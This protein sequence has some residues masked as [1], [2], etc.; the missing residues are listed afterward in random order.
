MST[1]DFLNLLR[2]ISPDCPDI[3]PKDRPIGEKV[4]HMYHHVPFKMLD[5]HD[6]TPNLGRAFH[7]VALIPEDKPGKDRFG[8]EKVIFQFPT[9]YDYDSNI[10]GRPETSYTKAVLNDLK[11]EDGHRTTNIPSLITNIQHNYAYYCEMDRE[12]R[13]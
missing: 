11:R 6:L 5:N 4:I 9:I 13:V 8:R 7:Y 3:Y 12:E 10:G 2:D 1:Y